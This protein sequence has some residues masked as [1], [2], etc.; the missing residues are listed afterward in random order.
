MILNNKVDNDTL[1]KISLIH[2]IEYNHI[3]DQPG[4]S[5]FV[6]ALF[7]RQPDYNDLQQLA[8]TKVGSHL[9]IVN[10]Y[11]QF[12]CNNTILIQYWHFFILG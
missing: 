10:L 12:L 8:F 7:T 2:F 11:V 1:L 6:R 9:H 3:K 5:Y 4:D